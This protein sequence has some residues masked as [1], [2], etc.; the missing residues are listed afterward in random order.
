MAGSGDRTRRAFELA[1]A[2]ALLS[3]TP[4]VLDA[5]LRGL[6]AGW[7]SAHEGGES[8]SPYDVVGHLIHGE[9]RDWLPR[10]TRILEH[11]TAVPL[12]RFDRF[13]QFRDS[14]GKTL[15][16]LLEEFA[17]LRGASLRA[18]DGLALQPG[19]LDRRGLHPILGEV[20]V[21]QLLAT[22]VAHDHDHIVQIARVL[23]NQYADEV[24]PWRQFLR[25]ISGQP[26]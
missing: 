26:G 9:L 12:D 10:L 19:D 25:V 18:L 14:P 8:W 7:D 16:E 13:A 2:R 11:G 22:W 6:P 5:W 21:R 1:E 23:A 20:T 3:R 4:A 17:G 24:G 15:E